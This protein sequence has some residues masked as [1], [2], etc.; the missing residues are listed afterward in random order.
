M[1][2]SKLKEEATANEANAQVKQDLTD[3]ETK[4]ASDENFLSTGQ[5]DTDAGVAAGGAALLAQGAGSTAPG[6]H[7]SRSS[8]SR[9]DA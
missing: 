8:S 2:N 5:D 7:S 1:L 4:V 9:G 6:I 3:T